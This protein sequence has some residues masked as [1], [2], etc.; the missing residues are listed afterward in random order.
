M[1]KTLSDMRSFRPDGNHCDTPDPEPKPP[2][3][4]AALAEALT[5]LSFAAQRKIPRVGNDRLKTPWDLDHERI[6]EHL[7]LWELAE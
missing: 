6:N 3:D 5:H 2:T 7:T 4:R 1:T